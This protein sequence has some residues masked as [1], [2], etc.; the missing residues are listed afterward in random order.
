[1]IANILLSKDSGV[2]LH[3]RD[4]ITTRPRVVLKNILDLMMVAV[5]IT[6]TLYLLDDSNRGASSM[7]QG[8]STVN[9]NAPNVQTLPTDPRDA[10]VTSELA[11]VCNFRDVIARE[12][13]SVDSR[14]HSAA[15]QPVDFR[16]YY[17]LRKILSNAGR[18]GLND[19]IRE[20]EVAI[21]LRNSPNFNRNRDQP[22]VA[23][24]IR[25]LHQTANSCRS[26]ALASA[27]AR[28]RNVSDQPGLAN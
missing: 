24:A 10:A 18:T 13:T 25:N 1:M 23:R 26:G 2:P 5:I 17:T 16:R 20:I 4:G 11:L 6:T 21:Q 15:P 9:Q 12:L 3:R 8:T 19:R 27:M 28:I 7:S 22:S 14:L